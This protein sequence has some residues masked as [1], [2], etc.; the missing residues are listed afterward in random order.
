MS[1]RDLS[2]PDK[3]Y[4]FIM[5]SKNHITQNLSTQYIYIHSTH[6]GRVP[7]SNSINI[8]Y[9]GA[10]NQKLILPS[11]I[12]NAEDNSILT[13]VSSITGETKFLPIPQYKQNI[14]I[15]TTTDTITAKGTS[16][17]N[18]LKTKITPTNN[19]S[20]IKITFVATILSTLLTNS[21]TI[22]ISKDDNYINTYTFSNFRYHAPVSIIHYDITNTLKPIEYAITIA[23]ANNYF[24]SITINPDDYINS[25]TIATMSLEELQTVL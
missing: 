16:V 15:S 12:Q 5:Y 3:L 9:D 7:N 2:S 4:Y 24:S 18:I 6:N 17:N 10:T 21:N 22:T 8:T 19:S 25:Q 23:C 20:L 13:L 1:I 11:E 14:R